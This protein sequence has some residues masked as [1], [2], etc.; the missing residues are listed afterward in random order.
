MLVRFHNC[1][2]LCKRRANRPPPC[3]KDPG[4]AELVRICEPRFEPEPWAAATIAS[5]P[6][7]EHSTARRR[8]FKKKYAT[9]YSGEKGHNVGGLACP[10]SRRRSRL[11]F[12]APVHRAHTHQ[13]AQVGRRTV[14]LRPAAWCGWLIPG[15]RRTTAA[16]PLATTRSPWAAPAPLSSSAERPQTGTPCGLFRATDKGYPCVTQ[17][18]DRDETGWS[19]VRGA[20]RSRRLVGGSSASWAGALS[21]VRSNRALPTRMPAAGPMPPAGADLV[22]AEVGAWSNPLSPVEAEAK[23]PWTSASRPCH[24]L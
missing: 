2:L 10:G 6:N 3:R 5:G 12:H 9:P 14:V 19:D 1:F 16:P 15:G 18:G 22:I 23:P 20:H 21:F 8:F 17:L 7:K 13:L 11:L 4:R 24:W